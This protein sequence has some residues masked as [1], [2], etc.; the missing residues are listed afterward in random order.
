MIWL[1]LVLISVLSYAVSTL[2]KRVFLKDDK[3]DVYTYTVVFQFLIAILVF[4]YTLFTGFNIPDIRLFSWNLLLMVALYNIANLLFFKGL[5]SIEASET[6]ILVSS[7]AIWV[8]VSASLFLRETVSIGR[9][10]GAFLII[11]GILII[12]LKNKLWRFKKG[13]IF[14]LLSALFYG[15]A[16]TNDAFILNSMEAPTFSVLSF[17][18]PAI[19]LLLINPRCVKN[20]PYILNKNRFLK[21]LGA[22][23]LHAIAAVTVY[24]AYRNG[25]DASQISPLSQTTT[26]FVVILSY[27]FL[28]EKDNIFRKILGSVI[29][30]LGVL[31]LIS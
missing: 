31:M 22:A 7:S 1:F 11:L 10:L 4:I 20:V 12:S 13:H 8:M 14:I 18:L 28:K 3:S 2:F 9:I 17:G 6:S 29:S 23:L 16:F 26:I 21:I 19:A 25:G 30:F 27:F 24:T 5:K 15:V